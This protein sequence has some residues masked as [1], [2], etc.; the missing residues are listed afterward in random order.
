MD[1]LGK[2]M[3]QQYDNERQLEQTVAERKF[4]VIKIFVLFSFLCWCM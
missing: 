4:R 1:E 3:T 2:Y